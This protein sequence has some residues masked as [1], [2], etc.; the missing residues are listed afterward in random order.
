M[1][2]ITAFGSTLAATAV[3]CSLLRLLLP[4]S[5][6][7][8]VV[9]VILSAFFLLCL[10]LPLQELQLDTLW[11]GDAGS[12]ETF[13]N[14]ALEQMSQESLQRSIAQS[15]ESLVVARLSAIGIQPQ[16]VLATVNTGE[17]GRIDISEIRLVLASQDA[18]RMKEA[19]SYIQK[20]LE[21]PCQGQVTEEVEH[22]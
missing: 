13:S 10:L 11:R 5:S 16:K 19:T 22:E 3:G 6:T 21:L 2:E 20:E 14:G 1:S 15:V 18:D 17:E 12:E 7:A 8:R 4:E 9:R